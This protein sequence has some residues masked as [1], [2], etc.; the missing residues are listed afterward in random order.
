LSENIIGFDI[1]EVCPLYD[2]GETALLAARF[3]KSI[4]EEIWLNKK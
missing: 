2:K 1:V 4:I 3:V